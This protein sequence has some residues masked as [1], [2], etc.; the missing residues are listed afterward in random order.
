[1]AVNHEC[2]GARRENSS[3][4]QWLSERKEILEKI[5]GQV[6]LYLGEESPDVTLYAQSYKNDIYRLWSK[7]SKSQVHQAVKQANVVYGGDFHPFAQAQRTHLR[8]LRELLGERE[9]V[10]GLECFFSDKQVF[11]DAYLKNEISEDEFL[12]KVEWDELWGFPWTH[13]RPLIEFARKNNIKIL[14]LNKTTAIRTGES[15]HLRDDWAAEI[16]SQ[17]LQSHPSHLHYVIF[18]DLHMAENHLPQSVNK[19]AQKEVQAVTLYLNSEKIYFELMEQGLESEVEFVQY[20][21]SQFCIL[22]SPPWVKWQ[23]YLMY[24][25]ENFDIDLEDEEEWELRVDHTDH[26]SSLVD[27]ICAGLHMTLKTDDIEVYSLKDPQLLKMAK[28]ILSD[29]E[30]EM[31]HSLVQQDMGFYVPQKGFFYL[32]K[33]TVNHAATLASQYIHGK[34][35]KRNRLLWDL[36]ED[37]LS[38]IWIEAMGFLLSKLVNPKRK[39]QTMNDLK[40]QLKAFDTNDQARE[41]LLLALD[42]KMS[43]LLQVYKKTERNQNYRPR[44]KSSYAH[45][46]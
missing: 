10:L 14:A 11:I 24:L 1:M 36:P 2:V 8:I 25:E 28:K 46:A 29:H 6:Q 5:K 7:S 39:A 27:M 4:V 37:F 35:S 33:A 17:S 19:K 31:A 43:E 44:N 40:K 23:S 38:L 18:G 42:Q 15:L 21:E 22:S 41:P 3:D 13:Y 12:D 16:V 26:V 32:S 20:N 34:M 45:A 30:Y 9:I